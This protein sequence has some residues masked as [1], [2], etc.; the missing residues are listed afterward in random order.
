MMNSR[1][2]ILGFLAVAGLALTAPLAHAQTPRATLDAST[3]GTIIAACEAYA[4][5]HAL[6]L[7]IAV[8]DE[9]ANLQALSRMDGAILAS[10]EIAQ[11]KGRTAANLGQLT[12]GLGAAAQD[13]PEIYHVPGLATLQGGVP[14]RTAAGEL[15]GGVGA[16]GASS[17]DDEACAMAGIMAAG[18]TY[19]RAGAE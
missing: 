2:A 7:T 15:I 4:D 1:T 17:A 19:Q 13:R 10:L 6:K 16:S 14:I 5:E 9:G 11:W 8:F 12:G 3:A 18:L